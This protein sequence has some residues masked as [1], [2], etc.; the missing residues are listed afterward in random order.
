MFWECSGTI[1]GTFIDDGN[2]FLGTSW[3][4]PGNV[5]EYGGNDRFFRKVFKIVVK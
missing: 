4:C 2:V 3:D 1:L 5:W